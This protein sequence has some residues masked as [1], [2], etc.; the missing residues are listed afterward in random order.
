[1]QTLWQVTLIS[2]VLVLLSACGT[3][4][5]GVE[6]APTPDHA[7]QATVSALQEQN[8][9]LATR[10]AEL[11]T[12]T[13][14]PAHSLGRLAYVKQGDIWV[15]DVPDGKAV[16]IT[17][18]GQ[19]RQPM[20]NP[21]G[22]WVAYYK[23][24]DVWAAHADGSGARR[25]A[26]KAVRA[27]W[28]PTGS[29]APFFDKRGELWIQTGD[30]S[31]IAYSPSLTETREILPAGTLGPSG[32]ATL[33]WANDG[34]LAWSGNMDDIASSGEWKQELTVQ[35]A[36]GQDK[37]ALPLSK[38]IRESYLQLVSWIPGTRLILAGS[39]LLANSLWVDGVPLVTINADTGEIRQ[40]DA[41]MLLTPGAYAWK[42]GAD[43]LMGLAEGAS[44]FLQ[45]NKRLS[46]LNTLSG[47]MTRVTDEKL[48]AFEPAWSPGGK[49][50]AFDASPAVSQPQ[51]DGSSMEGA[52]RGRAIYVAS[53][54]TGKVTTCT[55]PDTASDYA[56]RWAGDDEH[57]LYVR[58]N[59]TTAE[60]RLTTCSQ[61]GSGAAQ[62]DEVLVSGLNVER[63]CYYS[64]CE[65]QQLLDYRTL[66][67]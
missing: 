14:E 1:M 57:L 34:T 28:A 19:N 32:R 36:D 49:L 54:E 7:A 24:E 30:G 12:D 11:A 22:E 51:G 37:K 41:T 53:P 26:E 65:W 17:N 15:Q 25:V 5:A 40:L 29:R 10:V 23:G 27:A 31:F 9:Q 3:I 43:G 62:S 6:Q 47:E 42:P 67:K 66:A 13:P 35:Q 20:L 59:G 2:F 56:P 16:Q 48:A 38:D 52:L 50:L 45:Q 58:K 64:G 18:D 44:R 39:G 63:P 60:I 4:E 46:L 61:T 55:Q 8:Q 21:T 33:I